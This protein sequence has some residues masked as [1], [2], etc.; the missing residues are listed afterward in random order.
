MGAN[1]ALNKKKI[2]ATVLSVVLALTLCVPA[3]FAFATPSAA[4][5]QAEA[6]RAKEK[7]ESLQVI[8]DE[9]SN[10]YYEALA[11]QQEAQAK[12]DEANAKIEE[13]TAKIKEYQEKLGTR[14]RSMYRTGSVSMLDIL[15]GA[16]TFEEFATTWNLLDTMNTQDAELVQA[17]K[18]SRAIVEEQKVVAEEQERVAA[19]KAAEAEQQKNEAEAA[20]AE[21][22]ATYDAL[23]AEA[24][25][26]LA[27]EEE[28]ARQAAEEAARQQENSNSNSGS[29]SSSN[30]GSSS[31]NN[32]KTQTVTGN[33]VVDRAY[34]QLGKP[35][36]WGAA[37]PN[38]FDCSGLVGYC[39]TGV[40]GNHWCTTYT[41]A[42]W[43]R[44]SNPQP[45]DFALSRTHT[46]V[47]IGGGMMIHAPHTG[48]VVKIGPVQSSMWYVRY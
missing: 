9:T 10:K 18:E 46:G 30:S 45:G 38:S 26:L 27:A 41:M 25:E 16:N 36:V 29:N 5:K 11:E 15:L 13:E 14:A 48:D 31:A 43:T 23:S 39:I 24:A 44:V 35:Y 21:A 4:D 40:Y 33:I 20:S 3:S 6:D 34:A 32:D 47:Y 17:T 19:E 8:L 37:G 22:Q 12:V 2:L 42:N 7:L 28:A 1:T